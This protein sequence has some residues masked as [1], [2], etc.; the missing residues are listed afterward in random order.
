VL[1]A[2]TRIDPATGDVSIKDVTVEVI[3]RQEET[4]ETVVTVT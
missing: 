4:H 2:D 1:G 3:K